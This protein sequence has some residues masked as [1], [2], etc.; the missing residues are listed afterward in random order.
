MAT[1]PEAVRRELALVT[2]EALSQLVLAAPDLSPDPVAGILGAIDLLVPSYYDATGSLAV[3]WYDERRSESSPS[4]SFA[5]SII[6]DPDTSWIDREVARLGADLDAQAERLVDEALGLAEKEVARGF[7][8][9]MLGNLRSDPDA[10]GWSRVARAGAC[11][12]CTMLAGKGAVY[13]SESTAIFA[14]HKN[15]NCAAQPEFRNGSHGPEASVIQY[16]ASSR[17]ARSQAAQDARN[18][19]VRAYLNQNYPDLPG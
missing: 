14:A 2:S 17:R 5:P 4:T 15:C 3:A 8:D 10:V 6:G 7:R 16:V 19:R 11:K 12:F 18:A 1:S 13:R 9:S